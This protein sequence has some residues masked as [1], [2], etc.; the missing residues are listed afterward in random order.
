MG[1]KLG[2]L[3]LSTQKEQVTLCLE[4]SEVINGNE[5]CRISS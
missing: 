5:I 2:L 1:V 3:E 4:V